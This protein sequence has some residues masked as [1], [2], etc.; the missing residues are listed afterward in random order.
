MNMEYVAENT[1]ADL[2]WKFYAEVKT[3]N[4]KA[5]TASSKT[6]FVQLYTANLRHHFTL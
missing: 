1:L 2:L 6:A 3:A 4:G 5:L